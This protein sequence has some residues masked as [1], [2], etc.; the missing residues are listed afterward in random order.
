VGKRKIGPL[1][2]EFG[3]AVSDASVGRIVGDL[4][5]RGRVPA[6]PDLL[7]KFGR[8]RLAADPTAPPPE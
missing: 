8:P 3:I 1:V 2:R 6:A 5:R 7:R 4:I